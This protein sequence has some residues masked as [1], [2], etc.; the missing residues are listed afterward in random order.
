ML[1]FLIAPD[2]PPQYFAGWHFLNNRLQHVLSQPIHLLTPA[3]AE[4]E[5]AA[6]ASD[7]VDIIYANPFDAAYLVRE[8]NYLPVARPVN[9][10]DE[11]VIASKSGSTLQQLTDLKP[12][13]S[14]VC[15]DNIDVKLIGLRLLEA[16]DLEEGDI[17]WQAADTFQAVARKIM[18]GEVDVGFFM[19]SAYHHLSA[20]TKH[21]LH[22][23]I[24]SR[25]NDLSH[26]LLVHPRLA[27]LQTQLQEGFANLKNSAE[28]QHLL[29]ELGFN[30]GFDVL[31]QEDVEFLIDL[32]ETLRD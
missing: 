12:G 7:S 9:V 23:L 25:I 6:L 10:S 3:N 17:K 16:V 32:I 15:T 21:Q 18:K 29:S 11:M 8:R 14:I 22:V 26:V 24:E 28:G 13:T 20:L 30:D 1:N 27:E 19:A 5:K 4:E 2:F 31:K